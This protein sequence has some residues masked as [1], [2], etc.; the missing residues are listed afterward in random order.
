MSKKNYYETY[1]YI[2]LHLGKDMRGTVKASKNT[3][4]RPSRLPQKNLAHAVIS[5]FP[6]YDAFIT[7]NSKRYVVKKHSI[8]S[9]LEDK[10]TY[11]QSH[12]Q[13]IILSFLVI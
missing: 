7:F 1:L 6:S 12:N 13:S 8:F 10:N 4:M 2:S 11:Q 5:Y 3:T 9:K